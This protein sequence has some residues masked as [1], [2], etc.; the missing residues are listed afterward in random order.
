MTQKI[1]NQVI[2]NEIRKHWDMSLKMPILARDEEGKYYLK[3]ARHSEKPP[4]FK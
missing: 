4:S 3:E 2:Q 1:F